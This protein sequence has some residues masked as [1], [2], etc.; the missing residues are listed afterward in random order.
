MNHFITLIIVLQLG[1]VGW[2]W[3]HG[4]FYGGLLWIGCVISNVGIL[5]GMTR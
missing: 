2:E 4:R 3:T 1:A 5:G